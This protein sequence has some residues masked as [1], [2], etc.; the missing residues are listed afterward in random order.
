[1]INQF[2]PATKI[3]MTTKIIADLRVFNDGGFVHIGDVIKHAL[4]TEFSSEQAINGVN[5]FR[6]RVQQMPDIDDLI[7]ELCKRV[8]EVA[9]IERVDFNGAP[10]ADKIQLIQQLVPFAHA[11]A[12]SSGVFEYH[13]SRKSWPMNYMV[14]S[15]DELRRE[16]L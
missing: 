7:Y 10:L 2:K 13:Q 15:E 4:T 3:A 12:L 14:D 11:A 5:Q 8:Y 16:S 1:M 9:E 6:V